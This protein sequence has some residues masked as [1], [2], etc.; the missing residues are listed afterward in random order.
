MPDGEGSKLLSVRRCP[1]PRV[2]RGLLSPVANLCPSCISWVRR[3]T[4][5][6]PGEVGG[7]GE[8]QAS[9]HCWIV[10]LLFISLMGRVMG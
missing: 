4:A 6:V 5:L 2:F 7:K 9:R 8:Q 1:L 10:L 3:L